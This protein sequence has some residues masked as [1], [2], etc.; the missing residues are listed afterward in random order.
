MQKETSCGSGARDRCRKKQVGVLETETERDVGMKAS[1]TYM[2][3]DGMKVPDTNAERR[4]R[5]VVL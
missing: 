5:M 3:K 4:V 2:Q 1:Q